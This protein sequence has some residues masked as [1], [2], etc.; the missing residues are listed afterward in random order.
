MSTEFWDLAI[1]VNLAAPVRITRRCSSGLLRTRAASCACRRCPASPATRADQL[2]GEQGGLIG[3]VRALAPKLA[4]RGITVNAIAPG[5]IETQMTAAMPAAIRE[6]A[7]RSRRSAR[8]ACRS[9]SASHHLLAMPWAD[10]LERHH[11]R[12]CGGAFIGA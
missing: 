5:F 6:V 1:G 10:G 2:R 12:V 11:L 7:R 8:A 4:A 9:T 3:F